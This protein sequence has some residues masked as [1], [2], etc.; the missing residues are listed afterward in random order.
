MLAAGAAEAGVPEL[1]SRTRWG[2]GSDALAR[3]FGA[4]ATKLAQPIEFGDSYADVVLRDERIGGHVF[5]V[6]FQMDKAGG[7]LKRIHLERPR[8]GAVLG[9]YRAVRDALAAEYGPPAH[10]CA[11][12]PTGTHGYQRAETRLWHVDRVLLRVTFRDTTL[13]AGEAC[14]GAPSPCGP[15]AQL[16]VQ[17][18]PPEAIP[19]PCG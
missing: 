5:T 6:Y 2:A 13:G 14:L 18:A 16:F 8:H 19:D 15:T 12:P 17:V 4:R 1:L 9:A 10:V 7:G 11:V 3:E